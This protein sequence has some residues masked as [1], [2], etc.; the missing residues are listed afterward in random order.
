MLPG[1]CPCRGAQ[2]DWGAVSGDFDQCI[3]GR[4]TE[5]VIS[6]NVEFEIR[7]ANLT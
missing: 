5:A 4:A 7:R 6:P 2:R 1:V 3:A